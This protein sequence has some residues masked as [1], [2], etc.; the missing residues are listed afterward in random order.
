MN[1]MYG[2]EPFV[3]GCVRCQGTQ[4][5]RVVLRRD[6]GFICKSCLRYGDHVM[7][8][9]DS[10]TFRLLCKTELEHYELTERLEPLS[11]ENFEE[12]YGFFK[13]YDGIALKSARLL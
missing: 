6:G 7:P 10:K 9:R 12:L 4:H 2:I 3:D 5:I 11:S 1:R 13:D 8:R